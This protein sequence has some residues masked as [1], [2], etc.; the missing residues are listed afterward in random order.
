MDDHFRLRATR[1]ADLDT[2]VH[3]ETTSFSDPWTAAMLAG[4]LAGDGAVALVAERD[5][6]VVASVIARVAGDEGEVLTIAV[7][8]DHRRQGL[9]RRVLEAAVAAMAERGVRTAWLEVRPSN[10][11]ARRM[12][13]A[14]GFVAVGVRRGYYRRPTEDALVLKRQLSVPGSSEG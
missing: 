5:D 1:P 13:L 10:L 11:A 7:A 8:V 4:A 9:G 14:A 12:Y 2:L 6:E 3:L